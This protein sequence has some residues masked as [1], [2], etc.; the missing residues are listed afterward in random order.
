MVIDP[1]EHSSLASFAE[2][3]S[4]L[5]FKS[6]KNKAARREAR[7]KKKIIS[8]VDRDELTHT[9]KNKLR[10]LIS[11]KPKDVLKMRLSRLSNKKLDAA[12]ASGP[13]SFT[14]ELGFHG[15]GFEQFPSDT[16]TELNKWHDNYQ[17]VLKKLQDKIE[18]KELNDYESLTFGILFGWI[19]GV[20]TGYFFDKFFKISGFLEGL[21][22]FVA[23]AGDTL[24]GFVVVLI[25]RFFKGKEAADAHKE[26]NADEEKGEEGGSSMMSFV[27]GTLIGTMVGPILHLVSVQLGVEPTGIWGAFY[28]SAYSNAD[29]WGGAFVSMRHY[30]KKHGFKAGMKEFASNPFQIA[31]LLMVIFILL[32]NILIRSLGIWTPDSYLDF[33]IEGAIMNND[34]TGAS[35]AV[36][37]YSLRLKK[38]YFKETLGGFKSKVA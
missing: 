31:N 22:R 13:I 7:E 21:V 10:N 5:E 14:Y 37:I 34:S 2:D 18:E 19:L 38:K 9:W 35:L 1:Q 23:G 12:F 27:Y 29:N 4:L 8:F 36:W 15:A 32:A 6:A 17:G 16:K 3:I 25:I 28:A 33:A 20:L 24:G 26:E 11:M 30:V